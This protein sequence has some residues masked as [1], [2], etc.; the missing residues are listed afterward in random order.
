MK[1][2]EY[3]NHLQLM[4][5][6]MKKPKR[7]NQILYGLPKG[8]TGKDFEATRYLVG[9]YTHKCPIKFEDFEQL[10]YIGESRGKHLFISCGKMNHVIICRRVNR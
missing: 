9:E 1:A 10:Q 5:K 2:Q 7:V 4:A 8:M 6:N 3:Y